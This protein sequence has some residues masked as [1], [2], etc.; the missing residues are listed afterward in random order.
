MEFE[1]QAIRELMR[2]GWTRE[3][4]IT[5]LYDRDISERI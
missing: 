1:E 2:H 5:E 3:E 4:A